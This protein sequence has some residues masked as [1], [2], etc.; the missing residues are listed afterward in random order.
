ML[1]SI[2]SLF[3]HIA[4]AYH[5][6]E[7]LIGDVVNSGTSQLIQG[8]NLNSTVFTV[9]LHFPESNETEVITMQNSDVKCHGEPLQR[10]D[11]PKFTPEG[12]LKMYWLNEDNTNSPWCRVMTVLPQSSAISSVPTAYKIEQTC[13]TKN[14]RSLPEATASGIYNMTQSSQLPTSLHSYTSRKAEMATTPATSTD[15]PYSCSCIC[16]NQ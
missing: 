12:R 15:P 14:T 5:T 8:P 11:L 2:L 3:V 1:Y 16:N 13:E 9:L 7:C 4:L 6:S 10:L